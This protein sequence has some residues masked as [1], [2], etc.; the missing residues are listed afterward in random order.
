MSMNKKLLVLTF[1]ASLFIL[2]PSAFAF[3]EFGSGFS[4]WGVIGGVCVF[5]I[6]LTFMDVKTTIDEKKLEQEGVSV[7]GGDKALRG[8]RHFTVWVTAIS[9]GAFVV[10]GS[11]GVEL[12]QLIFVPIGGIIIS[13]VLTA[14]TKWKNKK[15]RSVESAEQ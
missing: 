10:M 15:L 14:M 3:A 4:V 1:L 7:A 8:I 2:M 6:V 13:F 11:L 12:G 9:A 5:I